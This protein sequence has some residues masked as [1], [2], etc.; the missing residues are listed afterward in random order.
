MNFTVR[1]TPKNSMERW[2]AARFSCAVSMGATISQSPKP[3]FKAAKERIRRSLF[4]T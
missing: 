2:L 1:I 4:A 3:Q